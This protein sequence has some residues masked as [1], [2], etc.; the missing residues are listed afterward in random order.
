MLLFENAQEAFES[1]YG[2]ILTR[3]YKR[4]NT[5]AIFN[6]GFFL[7]NPMENKIE[8][9]WRK[10]NEK[11]AE[12]EWDWYMHGYTESDPGLDVITANKT[13]NKFWLNYMDERGVVNSNYGWQMGRE[14]Q[15]GYVIDELKRNPESRRA[16]ISIYDGKEHADYKRDTPCTIGLN[17][18]AVD[19]HLNMTVYMRSNDL[20]KG[21]CNDQY[22]FSKTMEWIAEMLGLEIGTYC[23]VATDLHLYE[24]HFLE[25]Q[26]YERSNGTGTV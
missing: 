11:Y 26:T 15:V 5:K 21:F 8:T 23:H 19:D 3:G 14:D 20:W 6:V 24:E 25:K 10:W 13:K 18:F 12:L 22:C 17:F 2:R 7:K 9:P 16:V 1:Y 4:Q